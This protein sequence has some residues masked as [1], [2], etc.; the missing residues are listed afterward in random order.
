MKET[1]DFGYYS[2]IFLGN[3]LVQWKGQERE[4]RNKLG[5]LKIIDLSSNKLSGEIPREIASLAEL[6][7]LNLSRNN[8]TDKCPGEEQGGAPG[9]K[10]G[11]QEEDDEDW[12]TTPAFYISL[13]V[14]FACGFWAIFGTILFSSVS[15]YAWFKFLDE[16]GDWLYVTTAVNF[17]RLK[18]RLRG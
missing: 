17:N 13:G 5:L 1:I 3:V 10:K 18:R 2:T 9:N 7:S 14:G 15:R 4:Y 6:L 11:I 8:I 12:F 16:V